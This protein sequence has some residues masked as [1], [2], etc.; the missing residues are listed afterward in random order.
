MKSKEAFKPIEEKHEKLI[1]K[2][3]E[4]MKNVEDPKHS[5]SHVEAV[6]NYTKEIL[7]TGI[8]ANQEVCLIAAYWHDVGRVVQ[9]K[10]HAGISAEML[11]EEMRN[12]RL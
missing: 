1:Q 11:Q 12:L 5:L 3:I 7:E 8:K 4:I 6:V 10:G 9:E 2:A